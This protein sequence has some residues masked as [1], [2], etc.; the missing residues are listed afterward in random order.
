MKTGLFTN[1]M[2]LSQLLKLHMIMLTEMGNCHGAIFVA[3]IS[4]TQNEILDGS[5]STITMEDLQGMDNL[6]IRV[7][8]SK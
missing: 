6:I 4:T 3:K 7:D 5:L 2:I 8:G 1:S